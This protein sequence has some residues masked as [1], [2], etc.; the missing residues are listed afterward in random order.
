MIHSPA[1]FIIGVGRSGTT[2]LRMMLDAHP[3]LAIPGETHF[4]TNFLS[5]DAD[6]ITLDQFV[7]VLTEALTWP[8]LAIAEPALRNALGKIEPFSVA[9]A[10]RTFY[11]LY[12]NLFGKSRW[13]DK[14][15]PYRGCMVGIERLLPEAHFIHIIRDG[16]DTALSYRGLWFGPGD[17]V[18]A[19]ARFWVDEVTAARRQAAALQH[20]FEI[21][22][23]DLIDAPETN[24]GRICDYL[25][26]SFHPRML[27]YHKFA[28]ARLAEHK[29][30][31]GP[32]GKT[33]DNL[34][35]FMT[36]YERTKMP[37]DR[38]RIGRWR[39]E[40]PDTQQRQYEA[41][42]GG[43]LR[44]LGYETKFTGDTRDQSRT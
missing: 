21:R 17:D 3:D 31:F 5:Q 15:P 28:P 39:T 1:P 44:D 29:R 2:L 26:L 22:Y 14:T 7:R 27:D 30:S 35:R 11:R 40:M 9:D 42:A 37:L 25:K 20:Y 38:A 24:L 10:V 8:N 19:Q 4:L 23:E 18:E 41:I 16:R 36:I 32:S 12:A 34:D 43:L 6:D 33:P 13:G